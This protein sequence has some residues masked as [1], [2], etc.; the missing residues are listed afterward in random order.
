MRF[1]VIVEPEEQFLA[2][3]EAWRAGPAQA[4]GGEGD[5]AQTPQSFGL[6]LACH[7]VE[8]TNAEVAPEGI[9]ET[10]LAEGGGPGTAKTAG[11]N[12]TLFGCRTTIAA[13]TLE[14]TPEN[15]AAWLS[16]PASIKPG[17]YMATVIEEDTLTDEQIAELVDYL[18]GLTPEGGCPEI[19][20][21]PGV[22]PVE[23]T[24]NNLD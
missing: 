24:D 23:L 21:E 13:G 5:V 14:N 12:L 9:E 10:A 1:K 16:D 15:L 4:A 17:N 19:L 20:V 2:W 8:G 22:E 7:Q 18:E 11:P 6:C 3:Q